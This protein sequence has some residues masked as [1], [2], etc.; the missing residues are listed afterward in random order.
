MTRI[1]TLFAI[2]LLAVT[3]N[4]QFTEK[5]ENYNDLANG[6]WQL[7]S[8]QNITGNFIIADNASIG[9]VGASDAVISTPYLDFTG[10]GTV[11]FKYQLNNK[12]NNN[13]RRIIEIGTTD[14]NGNFILAESVTL[15]KNTAAKTELS[16]TKTVALPS[17]TFR[18]TIRVNDEKGDGNSYVI[19]DD[20]SV[21]SA[22]MHYGDK[23]CNTAPVAMDA[24]FGTLTF[25]P[26]SADLSGRA[27]D[28]NAGEELTFSVVSSTA[29]G[30][31]V[32]QPNGTF[33][34]TPSGG[35]TG[36]TVTFTYQVTDNG[37]NPRSSNTAT[38]TITY[39]SQATLPVSIVGFTGNLSASKVNLS[40]TVLQNEDG[41]YYQVEKS[42][43]GKSFS[44]AALVRSTEKT[45][46]ETYAYTDAGFSGTTY[47]RLK[48]VN[49]NGTAYYSKFI[50]LKETTGAQPN[51]LTMLQN[52]VT[53]VINFA[54]KAVA[55][56]VGVINVYTATGVKIHTEK[57]S[58]Q[59]GLNTSFLNAGNSMAPG[60]YILEVVNGAE[61]GVV[62][63]I[64]R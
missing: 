28:A 7:T 16:F 35:F 24:N 17:G 34:F 37:Y 20:L 27:S 62:R 59:K 5:F 25:A 12:L 26:F 47:Y 23:T 54:Y 41:N 19:L 31:L 51:Q 6:C 38:V 58:L 18:F 11:S 3:A 50:V 63:F 42:S 45:G 64:R 56:G 14:K 52:P 22:T 29:A 10:N 48:V 9:T 61:K 2:V 49:K 53:S 15:D 60:A 33:T 55:G 46:K 44:A 43:D 40:W 1:F 21:S 39:P 30:S 32:L 4:A 57:M 36:G 13:S 8:T